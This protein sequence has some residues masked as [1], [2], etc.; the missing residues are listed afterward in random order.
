MQSEYMGQKAAAE[1]LA[2]SET[3]LGYQRAQKKGPPFIRL[4]RRAVRYSKAALDKWM[5]DQQVGAAA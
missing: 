3:W 4:S 2:V 5:R 1:Y